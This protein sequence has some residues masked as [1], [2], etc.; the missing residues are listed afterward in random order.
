[1][2]VCF[3]YIGDVLVTTPLAVSIKHAFPEAI[4]DYLVFKGTETVLEKNP[5]V[6]NV[7]TIPPGSK[8]LKLAAKLWNS[9]D[10]A[11]ATGVSDR[12][13][14]F[15]SIAGRKRVGLLYGFPKE[16]LKRLLL[17]RHVRYYDTRHVV[18]NIL[19]TLVPLGIP[20]LPHVVIG[21]DE[22]DMDFARQRLPADNFVIMHPYS[23]NSFKYWSTEKWGEL[24]SL[25]TERLGLKVVFTVTPSEP[26]REILNEI[27]DHARTT[28][29]V[30]PEPF[31][32]NQLAV[33]LSL[34][35]AFVGIDTVVTH[36][37]A[38]VGAPTIAIY[39]PTLTRY[40]APWPQD[41]NDS[42]PFA[43]NQGIQ[44]KGNV[45]IVQKEWS[46]VPC[47]KDTCA[48]SN[49]SRTEC[50]EQISPEEVLR[51]IMNSCGISE[52]EI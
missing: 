11:I 22:Q 33:A 15:S 3:R 27:K 23:R 34:S 6:N 20:A 40:W 36:I 30:L 24:A 10:I 5:Y 9:Y 7:I 51:E 29:N 44:R 41:C 1:L 4:V 12:M 16:R 13:V 39:G 47:N 45:T 50:L 48:I 26:D 28:I 2:I 21:F 49:H 14:I 19:S 38:A 46:C 18:W 8:S 32:L 37:A 52:R 43:A 31:S 35:A 25:V 42:S 17:N